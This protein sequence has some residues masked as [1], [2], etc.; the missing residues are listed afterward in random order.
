[1]RDPVTAHDAVQTSRDAATAVIEIDR[2]RA[3]ISRLLGERTD[4]TIGRHDEKGL[5]DV[6]RDVDDDLVLCASRLHA[7]RAEEALVNES[8]R[9][10]QSLC[11]ERGGSEVER[12]IAIERAAAAAEIDRGDRHA[13]TLE[14]EQLFREH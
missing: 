2:F 9:F 1:M 3:R 12:R 13:A 10:D 14:V 4:R 11:I 6:W 5:I 8:D 7:L